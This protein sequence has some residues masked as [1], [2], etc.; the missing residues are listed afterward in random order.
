VT[1]LQLF[2]LVAVAHLVGETL[3]ER[4]ERF[5]RTNP[6]VYRAL[7]FEARRARRGGA[8]SGSLRDLFGLLRWQ[9]GFWTKGEPWRL[10]NSFTAFYARLIEEREADLAGF[11][12][13]RE[14]RV[15]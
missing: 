6:H 7:V 5:H 3:E 15:A 2:P 14:R 8:T 13:T 4:F 10:N 11:F 12:E 9:S 1:Q